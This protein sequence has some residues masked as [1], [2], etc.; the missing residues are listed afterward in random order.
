MSVRSKIQNSVIF[1][2]AQVL[3]KSSQK[4]I[5]A[6]IILQIFLSLIDLIGVAVMG[7][8]GALA[9]SGVQSMQPGDRVSSILNALGLS[10]LQFQNQV[11]ILT[12]AATTI[13][14]LRTIISILV[15]RRIFFFLSRQGAKISSDLTSKLLS[16]PLMDVQSRSTQETLY[17]LT[18]GVEAIT[19]GV[20]G[21][22]ITIVA[23][24]SLL[25][26]LAIGLFLLDPLIAFTSIIFFGLLG[27]ALYF[28]MSVKAQRLGILNAELHV[29]SNEKIIEVL[30]SYREL[31]VRNRRNYYVREIKKLR[32]KLAEVLA[33]IR[34]MPNI[35]KYII[36][37]GVVVGGVAI[38]A[39]Q[40][41]L[42][43][44]RNAVATLAVFLAAGTRIAPAIMRLQ[45]SFV[46]MKNGIGSALPSLHLIESLKDSKELS[47]VDDDLDLIH[48]GFM[49][50]ILM[51]SVLLTYAGNQSRALNSVSLQINEG[52]S[53]AIVGPSGAGKTSLV[54]VLLGVHTPSSGSVLISDCSPLEAIAKWPGSISYVPQ[55]IMISNGTFR[56]NV[57]FGYPVSA[58]KDEDIWDA[59]EKA[60]LGDF[61][62]GLPLGLDTPVGER[63][64][65]ISGGQRQ[66]LGIAR[67]MFTKPKLLI[68]DEATSS[69][70]GQ[71]ELEI[72]DALKNLKGAVTVVMIAHRL[73]TVRSA[74]QVLYMDEGKIIARGTFDEVRL[75]VPNF[76]HQAQLMGL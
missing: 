71:A 6:V 7:L 38:A 58:I 74:D 8:I 11:A 46:Q 1:R 31:L 66:R 54:D 43:D 4:K 60:N 50:E 67:A 5:I 36:E 30:Q 27:L 41:A 18:G 57:G 61:V 62:R 52:S 17:G 15:T 56:E 14:V 21:T 37:S 28:Q 65:K 34:F 70:D 23:D 39:V 42:Q 16:K 26:V 69:L 25:F 49:P 59:L 32:L 24:L 13:L 51:D 40:F 63:G 10:N 2:S 29:A 75:A 12:L 68:L 45:Q 19:L 20:L 73:S 44:A 76:D 53:L 35:S 33:E 55:D 47:E 22:F 64:T 72:S 48:E 3:P 9:V